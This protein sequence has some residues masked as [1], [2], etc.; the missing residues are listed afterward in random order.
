MKMSF[1]KTQDKKES[2]FERKSHLISMAVPVIAG[3]LFLVLASLNLTS[4]IWFDESYSAYLVRGDFSEIW[5]ETSVDVHPP[6]FYFA[7][8]IWSS[9]FGTSDVAMRFMSVF[10]GL[11]AIVFIFHLLKRWFG[12]KA[13]TF[14]TLVVSI[15]PMFI[16][17]G[18]EMR[19][20]TMVLAIVFAATY[21]LSLALDNFGKKG[22]RKYLVI[23]ALLVSLG[24]WTHY[25][26]AFM[27]LTHVVMIFAYLGGPKKVFSKKENWLPWVLTYGLS[28]LLYL[29]WIPE[30][31]NQVKTVQSGFWIPEVSLKTP[32]DFVS[33]MLFF[34]DS[35]EVRSWLAVL[36]IAFIIVAVAC[37]VFARKDTEKSMKI[38]MLSMMFIV[39]VVL[40]LIASLPPLKS[41]FVDRYVLYS[42]VAL[43]A[44]FGIMIAI[45]KNKKL[46]N[47]F[48]ALLIT[49]SVF[50]IINVE[51]REPRGYVKD[52]LSEVQLMAKEGTPIIAGD[53][54]IYY[55]SIFYSTDKHPIYLMNEFVK[56]EWGSQEPIRDYRVNVVDNAKE[57]IENKNNVWLIIDTPENDVEYNVPE[58]LSDFRIVTN[59]SLEHHTAL[60]LSR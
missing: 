11:I 2:I 23:Y 43:W 26:S 39:P 22:G 20:Y 14:G 4:S 7:L 5:K 37:Y 16:R 41:T 6:L 19:M 21:F 31:L 8:K 47:V 40:I 59:I 32:I 60:E 51:N 49:V 48:A 30:F 42:V 13:A 57:F 33:N 52:I 38:N 1:K 18:Q 55:D 12:T 28:V 44:I 25:F 36:G 29:P 50:G 46:R 56:Y 58:Y 27:F 15:S 17:Y 45:V 34:K 9:I 35:E 54:W 10:F 53:M 3:V 24:M